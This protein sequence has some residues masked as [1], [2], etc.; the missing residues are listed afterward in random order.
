MQGR[1]FERMLASSANSETDR[2]MFLFL[3]EVEMLD[4]EWRASFPEL[5]LAK[6]QL[7]E[8]RSLEN[9]R[10]LLGIL[11]DMLDAELPE[12]TR[13]K[14]TGAISLGKQLLGAL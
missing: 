1:L 7:L 14:I 9:L 2:A 8:D 4:R 5:S 3:K 13:K 6:Q 10:T 12:S 11:Y